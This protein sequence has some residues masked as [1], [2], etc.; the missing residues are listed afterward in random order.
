MPPGAHAE[1]KFRGP[2]GVVFDITREEWEGSEPV[3][4]EDRVAQVKEAAE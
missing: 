4:P 2:D 1:Y 3:A